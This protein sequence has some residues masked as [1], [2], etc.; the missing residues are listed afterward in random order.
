MRNPYSGLAQSIQGGFNTLAQGSLQRQQNQLNF[1][2]QER[3]RLDRL[4]Q[5]DFANR[6]ANE[7][8]ER[9]RVQHTRAGEIHDMQTRVHQQGQQDRT[10]TLN[11]KFTAAIDPDDRTQT[12]ANLHQFM[13][14]HPE[15]AQRFLNNIATASTGGKY[16]TGRITVVGPNQ[17]AFEMENDK[18]ERGVITDNRSGA[19]D[20]KV[21][22]FSG[23]E[24]AAFD[25]YMERLVNTGIPPA[26][27]SA[28]TEIAMEVD[29]QSVPGFGPVEQRFE[30]IYDSQGP[31]AAA[32]FVEHV[33]QD[34]PRVQ[35]N[36]QAQ[37]QTQSEEPDVKDEDPSITERWAAGT[38][39]A[40]ATVGAKPITFEGI[41]RQFTPGQNADIV[42]RVSRNRFQKEGTV[43]YREANPQTPE[44]PEQPSEEGKADIAKH[45]GSGF[46]QWKQASDEVKQTADIEDDRPAEVQERQLKADTTRFDRNGAIP[47]DARRRANLAA[48]NVASGHWSNAEGEYFTRYGR[49][50]LA[51]LQMEANLRAG[52]TQV[53][54]Q[55]MVDF[56][57]QIKEQG[58]VRKELGQELRHVMGSN[59]YQHL[60]RTLPGFDSIFLN[61]LAM[62]GV[63]ATQGR[64]GNLVFDPSL[65]REFLNNNGDV[66][67]RT[68]SMAK[69]LRGQGRFDDPT[70]AVSMAFASVMRGG[71]E[72]T[73][74]KEA[75]RFATVIS[76][77]NPTPE[78]A[79]VYSVIY[80]NL[81][82]RS[83]RG[84]V[85]ADA[86]RRVGEAA[87]QA[88]KDQS[89]GDPARFNQLVLQF[90]RQLEPQR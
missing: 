69:M 6:L 27:R 72:P 90:A 51:G 9:A 86:V 4:R 1:E 85:S 24:L 82:T 8:N 44:L 53:L 75:E 10:L 40:A 76:E 36:T 3:N 63:A 74:P 64:N 71:F 15:E 32:N 65:A 30:E 11:N 60:N 21:T 37:A 49:L 16:T 73:N 42:S 55:Q 18:G 41:R 7:Q 67:Q 52:E 20:D 56:G 47:N 14:T 31:E 34:D 68:A 79:Q 23:E 61:T 25:G 50:G 87:Y 80:Q 57:E 13:Q 29:Q 45:F 39:R 58:A 28:F 84:R 35:V 2:M 66:V 81:H 70:A 5:Q 59:D 54:N 88:A 19:P 17:F 33:V 43:G 22:I 62:H 38:E 48:R 83:S 46:E 77:L 89:G 78:L 12:K 26:I